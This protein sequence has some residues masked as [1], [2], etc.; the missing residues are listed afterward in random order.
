M[1]RELA[2]M[3]TV[4]LV[5]GGGAAML[6]NF[7][8]FNVARWDARAGV[9]S[10]ANMGIRWWGLANLHAAM[11][12]SETPEGMS[13]TRSGCHRAVL[14][15]VAPDDLAAGEPIQVLF[16]HRMRLGPGERRTL[17]V[18]LAADT[19]GAA[20]RERAGRWARP[21]AWARARE[22]VDGWWREILGRVQVDLPDAAFRDFVNGWLQVEVVQCARWTR[23]GGERGYR[24]ALQDAWAVAPLRP[25]F[26]RRLMVETLAHQYAGG[27]A[28][29]SYPPIKGPPL[30]TRPAADSPLWI[31]LALGGYLRETG[32]LALLD[33]VVPFLDGA[34]ATAMEHARRAVAHVFGDRGEHGIP[35]FRAGDWNDGLD[36]AGVAGRGESVWLGMCLAIA[37]RELAALFRLRGD[38]AGA[39]EAEGMAAEARRAVE[40]QG[41]DGDYYLQGWNDRGEPIGSRGSPEGRI[42]LMP[43]AWALLGAFG[44]GER[45]ARLI[46]AVGRDLATPMGPRLLHPAYTVRD[47]G[48]G[49]A[50]AR[51]PGTSDNAGIQTHAAVMMAA[52]YLAA[53]LAREG[54]ETLVAVTPHNPARER[55]TREA[56]P[57]VLNSQTVGPDNPRFGATSIGWLTGAAGWMLR[58]VTDHLL[59]VRPEAAGLRIMPCVPASWKRC[60]VSRLFRGARYE[61][62]IAGPSRGAGAARPAAGATIEVDGGRREALGP[63]GALIPPAQPGSTVRVTVR[64]D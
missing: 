11:A 25:A 3:P 27:F 16:L 47:P 35:R 64:A 2:V 40:E 43:Q 26:A 7:P 54:F 12:A 41:W 63:E 52:G 59:G 14:S 10:A 8:T 5:L 21:G 24:D 44:D 42:F 45:R 23:G 20:A 34:G 1:E 55:A 60:G 17:H 57:F 18:A 51:V 36:G 56:P 53:G 9:F 37:A 19:D 28:P 38:A 29:R 62:T 32:D 30:G 48:I 6:G 49:R 46:A 4:G 61:V 15:G 31:P 22:E 58:A 39:A 50:T 33:E 13:S